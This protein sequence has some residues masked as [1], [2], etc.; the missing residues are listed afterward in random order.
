MIVAAA[1]PIAL[2]AIADDV[3]IRRRLDA[4]RRCPLTGLY[5]RDVL[6]DHIDR[7]LR[8]GRGDDVH[9]LVLDGNGLNDAHSSGRVP[10]RMLA[11]AATL[12]DARG[13]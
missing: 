4:A 1:V 2:P 7:L 3:R 9:I 10:A 11:H 12:A 8:T 6:V 13:L 5:S